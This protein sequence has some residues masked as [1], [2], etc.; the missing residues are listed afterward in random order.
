[1][2]QIEPNPELLLHLGK[3]IQD[4]RD[5]QGLTQ[6]KVGEIIG[7]AGKSVSNIE[8][9]KTNPKYDTLYAI[10]RALNVDVNGLF[11]GG[12][13]A[14]SSTLEEFHN[15]LDSCTER[16]LKMLL[17]VSRVILAATRSNSEI[18]ELET[19]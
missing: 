16:E 14:D 8:C 9:G 3:Y 17:D 10:F 19:V 7:R 11:Y 1:M 13:D 5:A 18:G 6:E 4:A 15:L 2:A 12:H